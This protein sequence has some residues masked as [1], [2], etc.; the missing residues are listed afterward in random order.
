MESKN[1]AA[2][3]RNQRN[4]KGDIKRKRP[5]LSVKR[6]SRKNKK[7][8]ER[9]RLKNTACLTVIQ[10]TVAEAGIS[11]GTHPSTSAAD[12]NF[13]DS[14][15]IEGIVEEVHFDTDAEDIIEEI[16]FNA[17]EEEIV[18]DVHFESNE[19]RIVQEIDFDRDSDEIQS[20]RDINDETTQDVGS[21]ADYWVVEN[22]EPEQPENPISEGVDFVDF[23][24]VF[25]QIQN[26]GKHSTIGCG[27]EHFEI[28]RCQRNG[29]EN[30][31]YVECKMC[32]YTEH[33][34][35]LRK[36]DATMDINRAA[37]SATMMTGGGYNQL[38]DILTAVNVSCMTKRIYEK[39]QNDL[40][41][42][43]EVA[44][45]R[46]MEDA[47]KE[48]KELAISRGDV[49]AESNLPFIPVV[50]DGSWMKR[51]YRGGDYN[52]LSGVGAIVGYYTKKV[53]YISVKNKFCMTC[54][55]AGT[56][57]E[58]P[59]EHRCFKNWG[60]NQSSTGMESVAIVE[61]FNCSIDMHGLIYTILVAD[62]DSSVYKK[63][64]DSD[65]YKNYL[66]QVRKIECTNHLLRNFSKKINE[67]AT[68]GRD[69][70]LRAVVKNNALRLRTGIKKAAEYRLQEEITLEERVR[71]LKE[72]L[73][74]VPSHVF[75]EH[76]E[77]QKLAYFCKKYSD[78]N[79]EDYVPRLREAGIY[80]SI[81]EAMQPLFPKADSLLHGLNNNAV[82]S[83]NNIIAKFI[84][85]KRINFGRGGSYQGRVSA[86]VVQYNTK[87]AF[88][89]LSTAM[90]K[91]PS[92]MVRKLEGRRKRAAEKAREY[93]KEAKA[94]SFRNKK[95]SCDQDYGPNAEKPDMEETVYSSECKRHAAV[96]HDWQRMR[97]EIEE[98]TR[99]Q[100]NSE[101][102]I[103]YR[104]KILTASNFGKVCRLRNTTPR[105][106]TVKSI[107]YPQ[108]PNLSALQYGRENEANA[109][110]QMEEELGIH[111]LPC[112]L[113][114]DDTVPHLGATPDGLV[115]HDKIVEVKCPESAK[116][117]TPA[118][119][120][121]QLGNIRRIFKGN[122]MNQNHH[123][124]YQVQG[125]L[126]IT[127]RQRA[128]FCLWTPKG[129]KVT[130]VTRDDRF[131]ATEMEDK[132]SKFYEDCMLPEIIDSRYNRQQPIREPP[133][134]Q[135]GGTA[136]CTQEST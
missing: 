108:L 101:K 73:R 34:S 72:D 85:G 86:A 122:D 127:K 96:L 48:E 83:F 27:I 6:L 31:Y 38:E 95:Q 45:Q 32:K 89:R 66:V 74:N 134:T 15:I 132:L 78:P 9:Q 39:C 2:D 49:H 47:G 56:K 102:W 1:E 53:L 29:L 37:V 17:D 105:A 46:E 41:D 16:N 43:L 115:D 12:E 8:L 62:G 63:I 20:V 93:K 65:P 99:N 67:I 50:A 36:S 26:L 10:D 40:I 88:S 28:I 61:G 52:S 18:E 119:A 57:K 59:R 21:D 64:L 116:D 109:L 98:E 24:Y 69:K 135:K 117:L 7:R 14:P 90:D 42:A 11:Y 80:Q 84:G 111:I 70:D 123:Y 136:T 104:K 94:S 107:M 87:E 113:F 13:E 114:I 118:E 76:K 5:M 35:C 81:E 54:Q 131:W 128:Y 25:E 60:R 110:R 120:I 71:N 51:S 133:Y 55:I 126:H 44:A 97:C 121:K 103:S 23:P 112:G 100:A 19:E 129:M 3:A 91:E 68:K 4:S 30:V 58:E 125:Q 22:T 82:E 77:C 75:G 130:T 92:T 33:I 106:N 79:R 124:Y